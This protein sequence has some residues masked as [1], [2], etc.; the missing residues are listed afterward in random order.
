MDTGDDDPPDVTLTFGH[1]LT[2][3]REARRAVA[4]ILHDNAE[5]AERVSLA[6]SELVTNVVKHT[7]DG[8]RLDGWDGDPVLITV[9]DTSPVLPAIPEQP[10][11]GG[12]RGLH[13]VDEVADRW[14]VEATETG[15][16]VWAQFCRDA[17]AP[18]PPTSE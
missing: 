18:N 1:D 14:G 7:D 17:E 9:T 8:G 5:F 2:A 15:K 3:A 12:G 10:V 6:T 11:L 4:P 13:I 16:V